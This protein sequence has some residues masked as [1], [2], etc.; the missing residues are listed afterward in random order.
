MSEKK[1]PLLLHHRIQAALQ[2]AFADLPYYSPLPGERELCQQFDVSRPTIRKALSSL[3]KAN[4][5]SRIPGCGTFYIGN[6]IAIDYSSTTGHGLG[7]FQVLTSDGKITKSH[8]LQQVIEIPHPDVSAALQLASDA[9]VFHLKRLRYVDDE[10]YSLVD[11]YIPLLLCPQLMEIDFSQAS[12]F[13]TLE[14]H[15]ILPSKEDK[16]IEVMKASPD[17]AAYL[18]IK[19]G[20]PVSVTRILTYD[21]EGRIIQYAISKAD[22][23]KSRFRIISS[24]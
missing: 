13:Q 11:D 17:E 24:I 18:K 4:L 9:M 23:Y 2:R 1:K 16:T 12:L 3:E 20:A 14:K 15:D 6:K 22:A 19:N 10:L 8:V 21:R 5:I 7:L